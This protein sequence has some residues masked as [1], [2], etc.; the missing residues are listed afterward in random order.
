VAAS[1]PAADKT[2]PGNLVL[3]RHDG[4]H[5]RSTQVGALPDMVT[6]DPTGLRV[7]VAN[8]GEPNSYGQPD[9][10]DPVGSVSVVN[11]L[12]LAV[13][14][15]GNVRT[16]E[17]TDFNTGGPRAGELPAGVR[18]F[19]PGASVAQDLEPE[20]ITLDAASPLRAFVTL[21]ENNAVAELD[22]ARM[23][24]KAIRAL[25]S[26]DHSVD[27]NG[28]DASD[29]DEGVNIAT[30]PVK[31]LYMPDGIASYRTKGSTYLVTANEGDAREWDGFVEAVRVGASS[32][33][34]DPVAYP[35]AAEL[36]NNPAL[37]RLNVTT[38]TG[39]NAAGTA[40]DSI[41]AFGGRSFTIWS[42]DGNQV[43]DSGDDF[44]RITAEHLP[45]NFN[46]NNDENSFDTRSDDKGPEPEGVAVGEVDK[47]QLA[48]VV[49]ERVGGMMIYDVTDPTKPVF[50]QYL[51]NRVF[52]GEQ[53]GPDS[54]PEVVKFVSAGESPNGK[55]L[56]L[57]S[58]EISGTVSFYQPTSADGSG[59][60]Q[61]QPAL[62][63]G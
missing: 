38:A 53:V 52:T 1:L 25:G 39:K 35:N 14:I 51:N 28:F 18:I 40:F 55:P 36:K 8:E 43:W 11:A 31:A 59:M 23:R 41:T 29:R 44:E 12:F 22:L 42:S 26:K 30:W 50:L 5:I 33:V 32:Y 10:V 58:N 6:F 7:L 17:F 27:G 4:S 9:S 16:I 62:G 37:G 34:L 15:S 2:A 47:R 60:P 63:V 48:F 46:S 49:L 13:G 3:F 19:G 61:G 24:V 21:Q 56:V 20:Y 45:D 57:V 54:G